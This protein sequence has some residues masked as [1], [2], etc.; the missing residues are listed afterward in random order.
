MKLS[1]LAHQADAHDD[2]AWAVAW[3]KSS[4]GDDLLLTGSVDESVRSWRATGDGLEMVHE[5]QGACGGTVTSP[6][7]LSGPLGAIETV[8]ERSARRTNGRFRV[9]SIRA[10][11]RGDDP[12]A[13]PV[14]GRR[15]RHRHAGKTRKEGSFSP[16]RL[17]SRL[18]ETPPHA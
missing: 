17:F 4:D 12:G 1:P 7:F 13:R 15:D 16:A 10:T 11:R 2:G 18:T 14:S 8:D 9:P 3:C 5:Y 6:L